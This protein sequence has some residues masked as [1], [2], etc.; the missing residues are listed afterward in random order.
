MVHLCTAR[1]AG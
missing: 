1:K